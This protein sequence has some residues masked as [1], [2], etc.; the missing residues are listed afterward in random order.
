MPSLMLTAFADF[1]PCL[2]SL[3]VPDNGTEDVVHQLTDLLKDN[4]NVLMKN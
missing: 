1:G 4:S 3:D 2:H